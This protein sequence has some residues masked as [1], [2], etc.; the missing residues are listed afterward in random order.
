MGLPS[1]LVHVRCFLSFVTSLE[2][3]FAS[4]MA[5]VYLGDGEKL[6]PIPRPPEAKPRKR[7]RDRPAC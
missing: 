2:I 5:T 1:I 6:P 3:F 4:A 7:R